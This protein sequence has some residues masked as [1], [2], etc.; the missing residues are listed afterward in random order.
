MRV[1]CRPVPP[2]PSGKF[3]IVRGARLDPDAV[4]RRRCETSGL[5]GENS[6]F[7]AGEFPGRACAVGGRPPGGTREGARSL[8][9][10]Q[11][12]SVARGDL[13][14]PRFRLGS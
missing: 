8:R 12:R 4:A 1:A 7:A 10:G 13:V 6:K 3:G 14:S 5:S 2:E 11:P 9:P